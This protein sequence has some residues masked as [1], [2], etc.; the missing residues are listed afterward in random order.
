VIAS[1]G[2]NLLVGNVLTDFEFEVIA[3]GVMLLEAMYRT[4]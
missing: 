4:E 3:P 2:L 1:R